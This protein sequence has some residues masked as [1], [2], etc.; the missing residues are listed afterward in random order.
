MIYCLKID[1]DQLGQLYNPK[2]SFSRPG[3]LE[4]WNVEITKGSKGSTLSSSL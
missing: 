1:L 2:T 4:T 3:S